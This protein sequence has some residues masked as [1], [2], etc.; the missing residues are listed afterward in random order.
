ME[1]LK[2]FKDILM[3]SILPM[4]FILIVCCLFL[5]MGFVLGGKIKRNS[6]MTDVE[7][8]DDEDQENEMREEIKNKFKGQS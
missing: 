8:K 3:E 6:W 7:D 5:L 1:A 2:A 4:A